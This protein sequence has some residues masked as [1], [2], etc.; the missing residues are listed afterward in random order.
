MD[1]SNEEFD[2]PPASMMR[3]CHRVG[4]LMRDVSDN[5]RWG[6]LNTWECF[7]FIEGQRES[8]GGDNAGRIY[9]SRKRFRALQACVRR[10]GHVRRRYEGTSGSLEC[11]E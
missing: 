9:S 5:P 4:G 7:G 10:G 11:V 1:I 3:A 6:I 8:L 2:K